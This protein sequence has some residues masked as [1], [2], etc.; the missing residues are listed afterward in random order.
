MAHLRGGDG[1][2][3]AELCP[4]RGV[5]ATQRVEDSA[6]GD[7]RLAF[8]RRLFRS[9]GRSRDR[10]G[11][12]RSSGWLQRKAILCS[13][14]T[15]TNSGSSATPAA[16][17]RGGAPV[18]GHRR[19]PVPVD[20]GVHY[21]RVEAKPSPWPPPRGESR[22]TDSRSRRSSTERPR[23]TAPARSH[24]PAAPAPTALSANCPSTCMS[25]NPPKSPTSQAQIRRSVSSIHP[26][27]ICPRP[28]PTTATH[29]SMVWGCGRQRTRARMAAPEPG[30][31]GRPVH[32]DVHSHFGPPRG[33]P[34]MGHPALAAP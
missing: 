13:R 11:K 26:P 14:R 31:G 25:R 18:L 10:P 23:A 16:A 3:L 29:H 21:L 8:V 12:T 27:R 5:R 2:V 9:R 22:R 32:T 30:S 33:T 1:R 15:C 24:P 17:A 7:Q 4:E 19:C 28:L 20:H 6:L 34:S